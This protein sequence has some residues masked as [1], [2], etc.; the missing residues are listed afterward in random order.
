MPFFKPKEKTLFGTFVCE[1]IYMAKNPKINPQDNGGERGNDSSTLLLLQQRK[2]IINNLILVASATF[3][4]VIGVLTMAWFASNKNVTGSD[5]SV[6]VELPD[7]IK[8]SLGHL[9]TQD[10]T[11]YEIA[12]DENDEIVPPSVA[13]EGD[14]F[15]E[16]DICDY[17]LFGRLIP[18]SS[19]SGE[20]IWYTADAKGNGRK[21]KANHSFSRADNMLGANATA[22][23]IKYDGEGQAL[24]WDPEPYIS[25]NDT[26]DDGY[27]I[28]VPVW[29]STDSE[30]QL[31]L[32]VQGYV[33]QNDGTIAP[34]GDGDSYE[35]ALYKAARVA[36]LDDSYLSASTSSDCGNVIPL[37][38][39]EEGNSILDSKNYTEDDTLYGVVGDGSTGWTYETYEP[40]TA[41]ESDAQ[42]NMTYHPIAELTSSNGPMKRYIRLWLDGDDR[43]C[44]NATAGQNWKI[45]LIFSIDS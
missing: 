3:V 9:A 7:S 40:Y 16:V 41:S 34:D 45:Y 33:T 8:I 38:N 22:H 13:D 37:H 15:S 21:L 5:M 1:E 12:F 2:K 26:Q 28:D 11:H 35:E 36:I 39:G 32:T 30:N 14:W 25:W 10:S 20:E 43:D 23:A 17:Y 4:V 19:V 27:Y 6:N 24:D 29:F 42:Q 44:F 18:A 31:K